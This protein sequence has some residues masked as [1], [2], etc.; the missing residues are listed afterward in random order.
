MQHW[1]TSG[2]SKYGSP[3]RKHI[4]LEPWHIRRKFEIPTANPEFSTTASSVP[5]QLRQRS[6]TGNDNTDVLGANLAIFGC[7]L[8]T[9]SFAYSFME[10]V[11]FENAAFAVGIL[12]ISVILS[13]ILPASVAIRLYFRLSVTF[14]I[15]V[16]EI[17]M[18]DSLRFAVEKKQ[19]WRF[20]K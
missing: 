3:N 18:V 20:S 7:P 12:M 5:G 11:V 1:Q 19:I 4:S 17:A 10:F 6:T 15:T 2:N 8:L 13:E 14:K 9:Q 16:F